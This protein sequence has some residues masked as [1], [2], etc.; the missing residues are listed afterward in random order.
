MDA[1]HMLPQKFKDKFGKAK[2]N[3]NDPK[4][5]IWLE[6]KSHSKKSYEYNQK[7]ED[8]FKNNHNPSTE[9]IEHFMKQVM[10]E[11]FDINL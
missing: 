6:K 11:T 5:G 1:H 8:F 9:E 4:Y 7:W 10:K 2:I 3:I